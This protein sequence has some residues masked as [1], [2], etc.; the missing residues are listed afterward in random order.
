MGV[1]AFEYGR[2]L[3]RGLA[4]THSLAFL[5]LAVLGGMALV[6]CRASLPQPGTAQTVSVPAATREARPRE[7]VVDRLQEPS[8]PELATPAPVE[9]LPPYRQLAY[10]PAEATS[11]LELPATFYTVQLLAASTKERLEDYVHERQLR[12]MSAA[13]IESGGALYY[14]LLL[15]V[16]PDVDVAKQAA[17]QLPPGLEDAAVWVRSLGSIQEAIR[18]ADRLAGS[19]EF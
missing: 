1:W 12:S 18:R 8:Q 2:A 4:A 15:G 10:R 3:T 9:T 6:S 13:R 17:A 14:V 19:A 11:I 7:V 5:S 16:Y